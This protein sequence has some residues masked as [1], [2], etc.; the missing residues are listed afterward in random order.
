MELRI[1]RQIN[2]LTDRID[3]YVSNNDG[4]QQPTVLNMIKLY[5]DYGLSVMMSCMFSI[6]TIDVNSGVYQSLSGILTPSHWRILLLLLMPGSL[7]RLLF[8]ITHPFPSRLLDVFVQLTSEQI[9][10]RLINNDSSTTTDTLQYGD[11]PKYITCDEVVAN[12]FAM[13]E[14]GSCTNS[15]IIAFIT[16]DLATN[17]QIQDRLY[18]EL[19]ANCMDNREEQLDC[20]RLLRNDYLDAVVAESLRLN[21][22]TLREGRIAA[23]DYQLGDTGIVIA[24]GQAVE[25][26]KHAV[27]YCTDYYPEP[28]CFN[29][30]R[31]LPA[32]RHSIQPYAY[33]PFGAGS[34]SISQM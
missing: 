31:F 8:N 28:N 30:D 17:P 32:N 1:G 5:N 9:K 11:E 33:L 15:T 3:R 4:Q 27:H 16:Y 10:Q 6:D 13:F 12:L 23:S 24:R 2:R 18:D 21:S 19:I 29:P 20:D 26:A 14:A 7:L 25:F 22:S 34:L